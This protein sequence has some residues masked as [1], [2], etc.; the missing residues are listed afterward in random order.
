MATITKFPRKVRS[1][2]KTYSP[3]QPYVIE[4]H[5][6]EDGS[7]TYEVWDHRP[8]TYRRLCSLNE[9][10]DGGTED[11][12]ER[13]LSTAKADAEMIVRALNMMHGYIR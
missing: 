10:N 12:E 4:R 7:I 3:D 13:D 11:D 6:Q 5:D 1:L 2:R 8:D 9:W